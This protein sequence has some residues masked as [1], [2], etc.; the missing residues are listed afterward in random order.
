MGTSGVQVGG[1]GGVWVA[2]AWGWE[3]DQAVEWLE[4]EGVE[5]QGLE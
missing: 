3:L 4:Q 1:G 5:R 2:T